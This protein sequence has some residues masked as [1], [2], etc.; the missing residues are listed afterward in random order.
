VAQEERAAHQDQLGERAAQGG[1]AVQQ[2]PWGERV[3]Q[4]GR[5][6]YQDQLGERAAYQALRAHLRWG[7][8]LDWAN[9]V[10]TPHCLKQKMKTVKPTRDGRMVLTWL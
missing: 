5:A 8:Y 1:R 2:D 3:A 7:V 9:D 6:V 4:E 10:H